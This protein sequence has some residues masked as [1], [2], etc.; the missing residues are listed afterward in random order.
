MWYLRVKQKRNMITIWK[1][2]YGSEEK[3][4]DLEQFQKHN[5][6]T[7]QKYFEVLCREWR[8]KT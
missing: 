4:L 1:S 8:D 5:E 2:F 3:T 7:T 6:I